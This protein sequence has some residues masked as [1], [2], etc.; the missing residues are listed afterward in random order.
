[1]KCTKTMELKMVRKNQMMMN[2]EDGENRDLNIRMECRK[3]MHML[4]EAKGKI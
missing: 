2:P 4:D 3:T 1:M